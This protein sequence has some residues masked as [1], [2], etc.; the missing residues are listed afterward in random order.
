MHQKSINL[1]TKR[2]ERGKKTEQTLLLERSLICYPGNEKL[3]QTYFRS[4]RII[5]GQSLANVKEENE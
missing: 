5:I 3:P 4:I 2:R 1:H